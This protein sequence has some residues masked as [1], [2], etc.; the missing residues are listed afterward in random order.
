MPRRIATG[1]DI[2]TYQVKVV[3]VEELIDPKTHARQ[4]RIIGT[5]LAESKGLRHGYIVNKEWA[6][7]AHLARKLESFARSKEKA[8]SKASA[9]TFGLVFSRIAQ[10]NDDETHHVIA[11]T[12]SSFALLK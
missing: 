10:S 6:S 11:R 1:I 7:A 2:G 8:T 12:R 5:G 9:T 4:L 3:V